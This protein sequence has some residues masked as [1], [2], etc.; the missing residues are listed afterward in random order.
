MNRTVVNKILTVFAIFVNIFTIVVSF[1][2]SW[3]AALIMFA[4]VITWDIVN[5][6]LAYN[7]YK[8][9]KDKYSNLSMEETT[10]KLNDLLSKYGIQFS[11]KNDL[12]EKLD[13]NVKISDVDIKDA[14]GMLITKDTV[15]NKPKKTK[16]KKVNK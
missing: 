4:G 14:P 13:D 10:N 8:E 5:V 9:Y 3:K 11:I 6:I 2:I 16:N 12:K 1:V 7:K 15:V